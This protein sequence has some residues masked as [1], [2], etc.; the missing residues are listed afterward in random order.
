MY[1]EYLW[2]KEYSNIW[3]NICV[4]I[5]CIPIPHIRATMQPM[6]RRSAPNTNRLHLEYLHNH[7]E[8]IT[9]VSKI[10]RRK[11][12]NI[13]NNFK[14]RWNVSF[15]RLKFRIYSQTYGIIPLLIWTNFDVY[16]ISRDSL[17]LENVFVLLVNSIG[18][19]ARGIKQILKWGNF[20]TKVKQAI[21]RIMKM[22]K[23]CTTQ[24]KI[25]K[26]YF[27]F[28][29]W[30]MDIKWLKPN[31]RIKCV[32]LISAPLPHCILRSAL[33]PFYCPFLALPLSH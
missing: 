19:R 28:N 10:I 3:M 1:K 16:Q 8:C 6:A 7:M 5:S 31:G 23:T 25:C 21:N 14:T 11:I 33:S 18:W 15:S 30:N 12:W 27:L 4:G 26:K 29:G 32:C 13:K 9:F 24:M 17:K 20:A 2:K 22:Y